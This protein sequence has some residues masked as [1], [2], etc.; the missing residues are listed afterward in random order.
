M[1]GNITAYA[2]T[3]AIAIFVAAIIYHCVMMMIKFFKTETDSRV[4]F[5]FVIVLNSIIVDITLV[6]ALVLSSSLAAIA[7]ILFKVFLL[8]TVSV[9]MISR[10]YG[11]ACL[12]FD[13]KQKTLFRIGIEVMYMLCMFL[14]ILMLGN[15]RTFGTENVTPDKMFRNLLGFLNFASID[16]M[17]L[18]VRSVILSAVLTVIILLLIWFDTK[19]R[20]MLITIQN[21]KLLLVIPASILIWSFISVLNINFL[22]P[23][24]PLFAVL[25]AAVIYR[26]VKKEIR[27][28]IIH[29][30]HVFPEMQGIISVI[31]QLRGK[32]NTAY[33]KKISD[34][35]KQNHD[36]EH[37]IRKRLNAADNKT[38]YR[39]LSTKYVTAS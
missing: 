12:Y 25:I 29:A 7:S 17:S 13:R 3:L 19:E 2:S 10:V 14:T 27:S 21:D 26:A 9:I 32:R 4:Y 24:A 15:M 33:E 5:L 34:I 39:I 38:L 18:F 11:Y 1:I 20:R 31:K 36:I 35:L 37:A 23:L 28:T 22:D 6:T 8:S 30:T 16:G